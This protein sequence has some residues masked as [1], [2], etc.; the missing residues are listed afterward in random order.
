M[1]LGPGRVALGPPL[2]P[3]WRHLFHHSYYPDGFGRRVRGLFG[4]PS[5]LWSQGMAHPHRRTIVYIDS[6]LAESLRLVKPQSTM[7]IGILIRRPGSGRSPCRFASIA[8]WR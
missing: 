6:D 5:F 3:A 8:I 2:G 1:R 7:T 4:G